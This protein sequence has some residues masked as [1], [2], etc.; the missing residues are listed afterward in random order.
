MMRLASMA[1][2][3]SRKSPLGYKHG[4]IIFQGKKKICS[5]YNMNTRTSYRNNI[6]CS[7]NAE[8][9]TVS[10][11][12]NSFIKIH[13]ITG[14]KNPHKIRRKLS[15]YNILVVRSAEYKDGVLNYLNSSPCK[16]CLMKLQHVGLNKVIYS[17]NNYGLKSSRIHQISTDNVKYSAV[18]RQDSIRQQLRFAPM[19]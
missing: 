4:A 17:D 16:D 5:G 9:D 3:E 12:L 10:R 13:Q 11:F 6:C 14:E 8:M 18:M 15:K 2:F 7:I 1:A 19:I